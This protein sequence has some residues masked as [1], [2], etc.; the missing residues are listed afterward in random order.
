MHTSPL[1]QT[2]CLIFLSLL[3]FFQPKLCQASSPAYEMSY[4]LPQAGKFDKLRHSFD[5][6]KKRITPMLEITSSVG[7]VILTILG[8]VGFIIIVFVLIMLLSRK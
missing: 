6:W 2:T 4:T 8:F 7:L 3:F 1:N 5:E